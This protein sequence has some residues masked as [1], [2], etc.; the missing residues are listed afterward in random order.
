MRSMN[1]RYG[2]TCTLG[3][4]VMV[5]L[6]SGDAWRGRLSVHRSGLYTSEVETRRKYR[7]DT[8]PS[9]STRSS[10]QGSGPNR[11]GERPDDVRAHIGEFR[12]YGLAK[13]VPRPI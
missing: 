7:Q 1:R 10:M 13:A 5:A 3:A 6:F 2:R 4:M 9:T 12:R 8:P 11:P